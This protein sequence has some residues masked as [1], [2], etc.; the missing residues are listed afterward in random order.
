MP[1]AIRFRCVL[2]A[3]ALMTAC[4]ADVFPTAVPQG[5]WGGE[6][7]A[8]DVTGAGAQVT[9]DCAHG[10]LDQPLTLDS[11][12]RFS[13]TGTYT[14]EG[15]PTPQSEQRLPAAYSGRLQG[16][17]LTLTVTLT[18]SSQALG[19]FTLTWGRTPTI[20]KCL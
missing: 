15:G 20:T 19:S 7:V 17:T 5:A 10:S 14:P 13:V 8:L 9:F 16:N 2:S 3:C 6:H 12:A 11:S 1:L 18:S 4:S